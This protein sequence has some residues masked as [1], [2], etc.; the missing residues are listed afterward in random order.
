M[1]ASD[2]FPNLSTAEAARYLELQAA[3]SRPLRLHCYRAIGLGHRERVLEVGCGSGAILR[4]LQEKVPLA[5]GTDPHLRPGLPRS[6]GGVGERLPFKSGALQA[7]FV[8]YALLWVRDLGAFCAEARRVLVP[9][10][11]LVLLAEPLIG[12]TR[13]ADGEA[14]KR[15]HGDAGIHTFTLETL[16]GVL[17]GHGFTPALQRAMEDGTADPEWDALNAKLLGRKMDLILPLAYG[18]ASL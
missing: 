11:P 15:M 1:P 10:G 16:D 3:R 2:I 13:G 4:E 5:A 12:E 8:H 14:F 7:V 6:T 18:V 17:R 9:G